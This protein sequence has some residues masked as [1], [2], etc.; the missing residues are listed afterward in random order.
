MERFDPAAV[1]EKWRKRWQERGL[2]Q[3]DMLGA[4]RP[5][6]NLMMFPYPS[7]EGLHVGNVFAFVGS[8]IHGRFK[9]LAGYDV[10]EPIGFDSFGIHAE[11]FAIKVGKHPKRL[12]AEN[13]ENFRE[14][15]MKRI[16]NMFDW[17]HQVVSSDP[18]YYKWC[19]WIFL[20]LY[21]AGLA[22]R[23]KAPVNW[24]NSC[25]TV[26]ADEQVV[27]GRCERCKGEVIQ[28]E[29]TQWFFRITEFSERLLRNLDVID[30]SENTKKM[31]RQWIG[32]SVG[33]EIEF[34]VEGD[35]EPLRVF[36]TRAD[37]IFGA[38]YLL[39]SP[40]HPFAKKAA[41][42]RAAEV[43]T[44]VEEALHAADYNKEEPRKE[45]TGVFTGRYAMNPA[46][47]GRIPIWVSDYVLMGYG[48]GAIMGVPG[49]DERDFEFAT[50]FGLPIVEVISPD[51]AA[52]ALAEAYTGDGVLVNSG[53][54][55]GLSVEEGARRI[56]EM[57]ASKRLGAASVHYRLRDWCI[58]RQRYW[59]PPIPIIY[60]DK[61]GIVPVPEKDLPVL[62]PETDDYLPDGSEKSPLAR[63]KG[64]VDTKCPACGGP[65][66]RETDVSDN[67]LD[68]AWYFLRYPS[69]GRDDVPFEKAL[70][71]KWLPVDM[72]IGGNE[73]AVLHLM[74]TRFITMALHDLG[75]LDFEEPFKR[76]RAHGL[77]IKDGAKMSKSKGNVVI[78]NHYIERFGADTLRV[79]LMFLGPYK[80]G[81]DFQDAGIAGIRKFF[82][83]V[84]TL[85]TTAV[86]SD[87]KPSPEMLHH[88]HRTIARVTHDIELLDYNTAIASFMEMMNEMKREERVHAEIAEAFLIMLSPFAPFF[89][90]ELWE[91][92]GHTDSIFDARW[93]ALDESLAAESIVDLIV[94]VNGKVRDQLR[95]PMGTAEAEVKRVALESEKTQKWIRDHE[96]VKYIFVPDKLLNI[97]IR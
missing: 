20:Q 91:R 12:T 46:T 19:Q 94:Q 64:F 36:T 51:G 54:Y 63:I 35:G 73:H 68:S 50:A 61:C 79:Y 80:E 47:G 29:T 32:K 97:V 16:G 74:Y 4:K 88:L 43:A 85:M 90:E 21:K 70:T 25:K 31:Q 6:F 81:G 95:V 7:A 40:G 17:T 93:P 48:T 92:L 33:A 60:C 58:S 96:V 77:I 78:P 45:K 8:D 56:V 38:T 23:K 22:V 53:P 41:P 14:N 42:E 27:D 72:Y 69:V 15:Q 10:F 5:Y 71:K 30:W 86:T 83:R 44:Y 49:H 89:C 57:L 37:T 55:S 52:H 2:Y 65:A 75:Y 66:T 11:N 24:C 13:I 26:L 28:K 9:R 67:F 1:E 62:L 82:D 76:F 84:W 87:G 39:V 34:R 3:V 59:G 18:G